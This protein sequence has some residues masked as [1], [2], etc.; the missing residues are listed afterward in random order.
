M[1]KQPFILNLSTAFSLLLLTA[2]LFG[3]NGDSPSSTNIEANMP[4][5]RSSSNSFTMD[6][7]ANNCTGNYFYALTFST[8]TVNYSFEVNNYTSGNATIVI[9]NSFAAVIHTDRVAANGDLSG[10]N[11]GNGIP[12]TCTVTCSAFTGKISFA[13]YYQI[14]RPL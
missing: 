6:L 14:I 3:C 13:C 7:D 4:V 12:T 10:D 1:S 8:D 11:S 5:I 9:R 2:A